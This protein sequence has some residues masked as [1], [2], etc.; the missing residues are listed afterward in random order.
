MRRIKNIHEVYKFCNPDNVKMVYSKNQ[1]FKTNHPSTAI[2][3]QNMG[4]IYYVCCVTP[5]TTCIENLEEIP[6][7]TMRAAPKLIRERLDYLAGKS[8]YVHPAAKNALYR[9]LAATPELEILNELE[10]E[11][12]ESADETLPWGIT[13]DAQSMVRE[14][15]K[16]HQGYQDASAGGPDGYNAKRTQCHEPKIEPSGGRYDGSIGKR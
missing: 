15:Y 14:V 16:L 10:G 11:V 2:V 13:D 12:R 8:A 3:L 5:G 6:P 9:A 1:L 7:L 4:N